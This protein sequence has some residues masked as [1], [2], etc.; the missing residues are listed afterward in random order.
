MCPMW[1][2]FSLWTLGLG[3][4]A[5]LGLIVIFLCDRQ[6]ER[7]SSGRHTS[8]LEELPPRPV[9]LVLG[10]SATVA[11]GRPNLYFT[12]RMDAAARLYHGGKCR[13]F[14]VSGD[15]GRKDYNEPARMKAALIERGI[16]A[17]A[18]TMDY[19]GFDTLDSVL[20]AR[21]VFGL[22]SF[23]VVSQA[24]QNE[25]VIQVARHYGIEVWGWN[26]GDVHSVGGLKTRLREKLARVKLIG[27]L[28]LLKSG[29]RYLGPPL[30]LQAEAH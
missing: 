25:R 13:H 15:H 29:P 9:A 21:A 12:R 14:L 10:C 3:L 6:V 8:R 18:I 19:A 23:I 4:L 27:E 11:G 5:F 30:P 24:F 22:E 17:E 20:R 7:A 28:H 1:R 2:R 26:A 16:P